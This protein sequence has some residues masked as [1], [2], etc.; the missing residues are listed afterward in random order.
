MDLF[1]LLAGVLSGLFIGG[2]I[3]HLLSR[4]GRI[5][6]KEYGLLLERHR[7]ASAAVLVAE[8]R[9]NDLAVYKEQQIAE[10]LTAIKESA[11]AKTLLR[12]EMASL[13]QKNAA[14]CAANESLNQQLAQLRDTI[15]QQQDLGNRHLERINILQTE[16]SMLQARQSALTEKLESHKE[17]IAGLQQTAHLQFEKIAQQIFEEKSGKFTEHNKIN[18]EALLKPLGEKM[19]TFRQKVEETYDKESKQRFSLEEKVKEL[20]EQTNKVS[21]EANNL[22]TALK[23]QSKKQGDWG[24]VIL[25]SILQ[26]SGLEKGREY[27]LQHTIKDDE[28]NNK[29]PDVL[30]HLP[31]TRIIII[32][33][34]VSLLAYDRY[35]AA[36]HTEAQAVFMQEHLKSIYQHIDDLSGKKYDTLDNSLD[37]TMMFVPIEPAYLTAIQHDPELWGYAYARRVLLISPTNL[38]ACLKLI[39]NLWK[40]EMQ[41]KNAQEIVKRGELLYEK[42]V[43]FVESI[44]DLGKHINKTQLAYNNALGQLKTGSGNLIGQAV[45]LKNLGLKPAK[46]LPLSLL[47]AEQ[48]MDVQPD[49][50]V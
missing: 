18:I 4:S 46:E 38:I 41:S 15:R 43:S 22:A 11:A 16:N 37:F 35:M 10:Q 8:S 49:T 5:S 3:M 40:R 28:G 31:D 30:V 7:E 23:G 42:F 50:I 14:A 34:K 25:E 48:D 36:E 27:F 1:S 33:S 44:E 2:S 21:S 20:V 12:T 13:Q 39:T 29:R 19:E 17:E 45:K 26:K 24:E 6:Q 9:L 32:D 47:P